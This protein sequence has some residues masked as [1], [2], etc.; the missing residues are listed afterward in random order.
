[1]GR[2]VS[3]SVRSVGKAQNWVIG[4][5]KMEAA[6]TLA[7]GLET[8]KLAGRVGTAESNV[9]CSGVNTSESKANKGDVCQGVEANAGEAGGIDI[10]SINEWMAWDRVEL[11]GSEVV[12]ADGGGKVMG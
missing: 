8:S 11:E 7:K 1:M 2:V 3:V 5:S 12:Q 6:Q 9:H 10:Q 4:G